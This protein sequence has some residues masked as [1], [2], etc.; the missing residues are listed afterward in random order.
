[1]EPDTPTLF[2]ANEFTVPFTHAFGQV[3]DFQ[4]WV[5]SN[6]E[7]A[8]RHMPGISSPRGLLVMGH[9]RDLTEENKLKLQR[10]SANSVAIDVMTFDDLLGNATSLYAAILRKTKA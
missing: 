9:R 8:R 6:A 10:F 2:K 1:M 3:L 5:D 4:Q 7:Y